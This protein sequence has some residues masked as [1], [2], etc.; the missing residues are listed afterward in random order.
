MIP[1]ITFGD[2]CLIVAIS[3]GLGHIS[4]W[5]A[6]RKFTKFFRKPQAKAQP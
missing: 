5:V 6:L 1:T 4:A 2:L 3:F